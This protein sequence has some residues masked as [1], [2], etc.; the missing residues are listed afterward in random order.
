MENQ[1]AL[2]STKWTK[3]AKCLCSQAGGVILGSVPDQELGFCD[4]CGC[5][6]TQNIYSI[7][8]LC[9]FVVHMFDMY[10][11]VLIAQRGRKC[12]C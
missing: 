4:A 5:L 9:S 3:S 10:V 2:P 7:I 12:V 11:T 1:Y 6:P 8:P